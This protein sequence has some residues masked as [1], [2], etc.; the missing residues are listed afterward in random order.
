MC[1]H[2]TRQSITLPVPAVTEGHFRIDVAV[3]SHGL[4]VLQNCIRN[5]DSGSIGIIL[6]NSTGAR[7]FLLW[8]KRQDFI[9]IN[10]NYPTLPKTRNQIFRVQFVLVIT[11]HQQTHFCFQLSNIVRHWIFRALKKATSRGWHRWVEFLGWQTKATLF[12]LLPE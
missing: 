2:F 12:L 9:A 10:R 7:R 1:L 8:Q 4:Q 6:I 5:S 11:T 3:Q